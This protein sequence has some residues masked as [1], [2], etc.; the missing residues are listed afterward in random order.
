MYSAIGIGLAMGLIV[1]GVIA[2]IFS[3]IRSVRSGKQDLKKIISFIV[4]FAVFGV[5][6]GIAGDVADAGIATMLFMLAVMALSM[7]ATGFKSTFNF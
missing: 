1:I 2:M 4:P 6:Y 5:S 3:G 7:L